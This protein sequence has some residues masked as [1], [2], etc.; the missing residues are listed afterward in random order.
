[1]RLAFELTF[2]LLKRRIEAFLLLPLDELDLTAQWNEI[3]RVGEL[4]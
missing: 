3:I 2:D 1:V 4:S